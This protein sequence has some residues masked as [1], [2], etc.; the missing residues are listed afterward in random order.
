MNNDPAILIFTAELLVAL[1][2]TTV[3]LMSL[4]KLIL[5]LLGYEIQNEPKPDVDFMK[6]LHNGEVL[7]AENMFTKYEN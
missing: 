2:I 6:R 1:S 5:R 7:S 4:A 3:V